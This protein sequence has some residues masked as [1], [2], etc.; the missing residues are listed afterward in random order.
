MVWLEYIFSN[1][2]IP[3]AYCSLSD[4]ILRGIT[5]FGDFFTFAAYAVI[6]LVL[7][8]VYFARKKDF[9]LSWILA[10]FALFIIMCGVGHLLDV[11]TVW[12]PYLRFAAFWKVGTAIISLVVAGILVYLYP[13]LLKIPTI[14]EYEKE[15]KRREKSEKD[16]QTTIKI[17]LMNK[18]R[19]EKNVLDRLDKFVNE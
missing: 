4:P 12:Y 10:A 2:F 1:D 11:I 17:L 14:R 19:L 9:T 15:I 7:F 13:T 5:V 18:D 6:P 3:R 8:N 16:L